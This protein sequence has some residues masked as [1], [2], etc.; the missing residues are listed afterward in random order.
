MDWIKVKNKHAEYDFAGAPDNVF[1]AWIM[2]M[3]YVAAIERKPLRN[4][5]CNRV[6][7]DNVIALENWLQNIDVDLNDIF[8]KILEDVEAVNIRKSHNRKYMKQ[9]RC[10]H[11][12]KPLRGQHVK[13]KR[14]E[15]KRRV[16]NSGLTP[17]TPPTNQEVKDY[18]AERGNDISPERF[19]NFYASKGWMIGKNK[20]KDWKAAVRTWESKDTPKTEKWNNL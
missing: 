11:L 8:D 19:I 5:L 20:M 6:G 16:Y 13:G 17:F 12:H 2:S 3:M 7:K 14:R 1:R 18:C 9:Y 4:G 10:K 15:E